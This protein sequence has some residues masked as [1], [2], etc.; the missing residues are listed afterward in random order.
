MK[1]SFFI[2]AMLCMSLFTGVAQETKWGVGVN[3]GYGTDVSKIFLGVRG[4]YDITEAFTVAASFNHYFKET[5]DL[6]SYDATGV[7]GS[8]KCWDINADLHWNVYHNDLLKFYPFVGLTYLNAKGSVEV[9]EVTISNSEGNF[10]ANVGVGAQFDF[11][12]NWAA[13]VEAKYQIIEG[14]Q[15]VPMA[16]VIDRF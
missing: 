2:F 16:S 7:E 5:V 14:G 6:D 11:G 10:G 15:F 9:E 13:S 3:V 1:K 8:L 4:H 12:S